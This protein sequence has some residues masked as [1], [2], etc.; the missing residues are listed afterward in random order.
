MIR[1]A[2]DDA[3]RALDALAGD[4]GLLAEIERAA[5][6]LR[7]CV[8]RGGKIMTCGNGGSMCDAAHLAEELT[9]RYRADRPALPALA[10]A[11][12]G[13]LTCTANDFGFEHVF[14]RFVEALGKPGDVLVVFST[15]GRSPN[16]LAACRAAKA[17]GMTVIGLLGKGGGPAAALCEL[18]LVLPGA[19]SDRVQELHK[20]VLHAWCESLET[21]RA[22][23]PS[24]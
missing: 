15:S 24:R 23:T 12:P 4:A 16:I 17:R 7:A 2:L 19:T 1:Q 3:R 6:M 8:E 5:G 9:G 14:S 10:C 11:E 21:V 22:G 18:P 20:I 13:H